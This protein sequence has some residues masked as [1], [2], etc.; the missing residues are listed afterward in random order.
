VPATA[1]L[2]HE[3]KIVPV[4]PELAPWHG[5]NVIGTSGVEPTGAVIW[6][7]SSSFLRRGPDPLLE[8]ALST[9]RTI[10]PTTNVVMSTVNHAVPPDRWILLRPSP[11]QLSG[12]RECAPRHAFG[13]H[14]TDMQIA[15]SLGWAELQPGQVIL[16]ESTFMRA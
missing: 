15:D 6:A 3:P 14:S 16:F 2:R 5:Q 7:D 10:H 1:L 11:G 12:H 4:E 8:S 13:A 9:T